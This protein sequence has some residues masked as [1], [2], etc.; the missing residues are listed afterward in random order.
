MVPAV[1]GI[2]IYRGLYF[3]AYDTAKVVYFN[4]ETSTFTKLIFAQ[5]C[6]FLAEGIAYPTDTV[7]R[8]LM[9]QSGR[10][11]VQYK[12]TIDCILDIW[13]KQGIRGFW[14]GYLS[15]IFRSIGGSICLILYDEFNLRGQKLQ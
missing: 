7:K 8:Q 2:F 15:N 10:E 6:V 13:R 5:V 11:K 14:R 4:S 3:G 1:V 9:L 12:G